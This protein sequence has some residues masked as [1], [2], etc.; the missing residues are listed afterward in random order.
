[1]KLR[2]FLI[3]CMGFFFLPVDAQEE[4]PVSSG[5]IFNFGF[6]IGYNAIFPVIN[7][8]T[9]DEVEIEN[10]HLKYKV[11]HLASIFCRINIDRFFIQP[12]FSWRRSEADILFTIPPA[13]LPEDYLLNGATYNSSLTM[14]KLSLQ[15]PI[16]IGYNIVNEGPYTL[17]FMAGPNIK[18]NYK[19]SYTSTSIENRQEFINE[20]TPYG[21]SIS[22]GIGV[23]IRQL[24]FDFCY[25]FGLNQVE[26]VF[27]SKAPEVPIAS[28][29]VRI[30]KRTNVLSFSLGL[31]F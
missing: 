23:R 28:Y 19:T 9:V 6:T 12:S 30:D 24:F 17:S 4:R 25:E 27:K 1:M 14:K 7:S 16:M 5:K 18:Y 2:F 3:L 21:I 15:A 8:L 10:I 22:T 29:N 26:S 13:L 11:G 31:L 20:N